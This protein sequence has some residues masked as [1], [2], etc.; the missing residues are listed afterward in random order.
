[1]ISNKSRQGHLNFS[2]FFIHFSLKKAPAEA[3]AFCY[4]GN[5]FLISGREAA[6][7]D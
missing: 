6:A 3:G 4:V 5:Y 1:M 7:T 2:F